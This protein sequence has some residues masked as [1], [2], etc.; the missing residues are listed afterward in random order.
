MA[1]YKN[2][3]NMNISKLDL[4]LLLPLDA[5][6]REQSVTKAANKL[7]MSQPAMSNSLKRLRIMLEDPVLVRTS[8]G[9]V[10]TAKG[11]RLQPQVEKLL[12]D[13]ERALKPDGEYNASESDRVFRIM[14]SDYA[15]STL[16]PPLLSKIQELAPNIA[17]DIMT[18]S[19]VTYHDVETC[20]IDMA[21]NRFDDL[22]NSFHQKQLWR[23]HFVCVTHQ[24]HPAVAQ[25]SL[26]AFLQSQ[27]IW[28]SKTGFGV[29][30]GMDTRDVQKLGW[31]DE[32]LERAGERRHIC[33]F[34]RNY[35]VA[36][37]LAKDRNLL[38]TVPSR[39]VQNYRNESDIAILAPPFAVPEIELKM[40]W[41]PLLQHDAG[42]I[43][44][45]RLISDIAAQ[46]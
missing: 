28:V 30:V 27:H 18:P 34:T 21:L 2:I 20:R 35:H 37:Q 1:V 33:I 16:L 43:W 24:S 3:N 12:L 6:L 8:E 39:A 40:I 22:P 19:D 29:G 46:A 42:H 45:R 9:M 15:S 32:A 7:K 10:P 13:L 5:L 41:S 4:N 44:L 36:I 38:V 25:W 14:A 23:D 17:L 26:E 31:V 11:R